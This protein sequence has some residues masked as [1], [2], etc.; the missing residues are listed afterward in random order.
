VRTA[1][2]LKGNRMA[3]ATAGGAGHRPRERDDH[4]IDLNKD[5]FRDDLRR[6]AQAMQ[7]LMEASSSRINAP[8]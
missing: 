4:E 5:L 1:V 3:Y 7:K 6:R 8:T 2:L